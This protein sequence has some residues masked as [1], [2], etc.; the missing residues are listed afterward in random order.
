MDLNLEDIKVLVVDDNNFMRS[1]VKAILGVFHSKDIKEADDGA[2]AL[3]I[4]SEGY[5]P[6]L[7]I[8]DWNMPAL[9]GIEFTRLVR[10]GRDSVNP[11]VPIIMMTAYSEFGRVVQARDAGVNEILAKPISANSLYQR[12]TSALSRP[13]G[14]VQSRHFTGPDRRRR[15]A[16]GFKGRERREENLPPEEDENLPPEEKDGAEES[17]ETDT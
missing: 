13:R 1:V 14:F 6:D 17:S 2:S 9:D 15:S 8:V 12:I 10:T 3:K 11:M 7:I 4:M 16:D 5:V